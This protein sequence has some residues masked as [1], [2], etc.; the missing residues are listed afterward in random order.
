MA[1]KNVKDCEVNAKNNMN[2]NMREDY[3]SVMDGYN[4]RIDGVNDDAKR[5]IALNR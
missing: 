3:N 4:G 5:M 1:F 2:N